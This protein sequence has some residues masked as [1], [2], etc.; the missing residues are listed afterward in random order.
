M[1]FSGIIDTVKEKI[2]DLIDKCT[3][4]YEENP[5]RFIIIASSIVAVLLLLIIL[6]ASGSSKKDKKT[7]T[8]IEKLEL[9]EKLIVPDGPVLPKD[10][11]YTR[12]TKDKWTEAEA[13]EWFTTPTE[14][15]IEALSKSNDAIVNEIIGAAP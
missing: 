11:N 4:F 6:C 2:Q 13:D 3:E 12:K 1:D 7:K 14:S 10:Y 15:E 8:Y 9:S 5:K